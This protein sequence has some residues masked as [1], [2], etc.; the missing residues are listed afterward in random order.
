MA[1]TGAHIW[2]PVPLD[3]MRG[4]RR[5]NS[6]KVLL[7]FT[8]KSTEEFL[9]CIWAAQCTQARMHCTVPYN[10]VYFLPFLP[11]LLSPEEEEENEEKE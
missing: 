5:D 11:S 9:G 2:A 4:E 7:H 6:F 10:H 1:D 8:D 3:W